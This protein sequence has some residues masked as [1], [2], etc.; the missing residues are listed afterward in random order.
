MKMK[1][2]KKIYYEEDIR[3]GYFKFFRVIKS[4][5]RKGR[6][7]KLVKIEVLEYILIGDDFKVFAK[8]KIKF[9]KKVESI[10]IEELVLKRKKTKKRKESRVVGEFWEEVGF[11]L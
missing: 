10:V 9:K 2:K 8:K 7:K 4:S 1:K 5:F 6:K 11:F 3:L